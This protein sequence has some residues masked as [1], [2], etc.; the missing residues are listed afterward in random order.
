MEMNSI[1]SDRYYNLCFLYPQ[2][3]I[4]SLMGGSYG[5]ELFYIKCLYNSSHRD[6]V[7][8]LKEQCNCYMRL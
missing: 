3:A 2:A 5:I 7:P 8:S 4:C 1:E 6:K